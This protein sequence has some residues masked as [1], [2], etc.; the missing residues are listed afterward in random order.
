[1]PAAS[2]LRLGPGRTDPLRSDVIVATAAVRSQFG[3]RLGSV[4]APAVIASFGSGKLRTDI[5]AVARRGAGA[6]LSALRTDV[7]AREAAGATLLASPRIAASAAARAQLAA[8]RV[9]ARLLVIIASLAAAHPVT[10]AAF[11]DS[12]PGASPGV[13]LRSADLAAAGVAGTGNSAHLQPMIGFLR[14]W[15]GA[16]L[17]AQVRTVRLANGHAAVHIEFAAPS[18]LGLLGG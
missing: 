2:L 5:R 12:G 13:P 9:D 14:S 16:Y 17:P 7:L 15:R 11:G 18:P 3:S 1:V 6:Y 8:G 10:I 4:Y